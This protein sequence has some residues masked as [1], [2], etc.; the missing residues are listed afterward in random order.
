MGEDG[1]GRD[2]QNQGCGDCSGAGAGMRRDAEKPCD[3]L[4][5]RSS[6]CGECGCEMRRTVRFEIGE[7]LRID[8]R[9]AGDCY[10]DVVAA[11]FAFEA[12]VVRDPPDCRVVEKRGFRDTLQD[13][14]EVIVAADVGEL[15]REQRF[16]VFGG[17]TLRR[18]RR[19]GRALDRPEPTG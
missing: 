8:E 10:G 16:D 2:E 19:P 1:V 14:D 15:V 17:E 7:S 11:V 9:I 5:E 6:V 18:A 12:D 13:V 4:F 3:A